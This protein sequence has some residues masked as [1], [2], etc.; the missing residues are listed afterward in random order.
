MSDLSRPVLQALSEMGLLLL[1]DKHLPNIVTLV[2]GETPRTSWWSH[3]KGRQVF[4]VVTELA[5]HPDVLF[6]KL[7]HAKV[8]LVHRRLWRAL[9]TIVS[10]GEAWQL[11]GLSAAARRLLASANESQE[12]I[13]ATGAVVK[14]L[15]ARLL[16]HTKEVH[17]ETGR[18]EVI[19]ESWE[20]WARHARVKPLRSIDAAKRQIEA[21]VK[22]FGADLTALPWHSR[23]SR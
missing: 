18:H 14:E 10:A 5:E 2:T 7:L 1:Q 8:T 19:V 9:L 21:A 23:K 12:P 16:L 15:E 11:R 20:V 17:G 4:A 3:P 22:A 13:R 6:T